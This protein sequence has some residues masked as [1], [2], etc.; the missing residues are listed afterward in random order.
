MM[1]E[2]DAMRE[3]KRLKMP[4]MPTYRNSYVY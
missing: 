3:A 2:R 1:F 4:K